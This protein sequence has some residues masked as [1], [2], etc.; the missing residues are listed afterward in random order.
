MWSWGEG[1][2]R[3]TG[4]LAWA[5]PPTAS[6]LARSYVVVVDATARARAYW[7]DAA[8]SFDDEPDHGAFDPVVRAA[9]TECLRNWLP[10]T[11]VRIADLGCGTGTLSALAAGLGHAVTGVD[12][13]PQMLAR[14]RR[15]APVATFVEADAA[16]PPLPPRSAD[17]VLCRHVLWAL[18]DQDEVVSRWS[19]LL[20]PAGRFVL[21]EGR[22]HTGAGLD[23]ARVVDLLAPYVRQVRVE[24]LDDPALWAGPLTDDRYVVRAVT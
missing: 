2:D 15:K 13:S 20:A 12:V 10:L 3:H 1:D 7:D 6:A 17:V 11:P 22:W 24:T 9:W 19:R 8:D 4:P 23:R 14:A 5:R 21:V 16:D 18:P